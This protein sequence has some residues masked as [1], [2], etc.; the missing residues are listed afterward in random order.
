ML[1]ISEQ[2]AS[3]ATEALTLVHIADAVQKAVDQGAWA[4]LAVIAIY[5]FIEANKATLGQKMPS[6]KRNA[7]QIS[8]GVGALGGAVLA[9][10]P[11]NGALGG[12]IIGN[13]ASGFYASF[14]KPL[15][16]VFGAKVGATVWLALKMFFLA[17]EGMKNTSQEE[18]KETLKELDEA[19]KKAKDKERPSTKELEK[20]FSKHV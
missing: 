2:V 5:V 7:A 8:A 4:F 10:D 12:L 3:Q 9:E 1:D 13:A 6:V 15:M 14:M 19:L 20:W 18:K 11:V 16:A 17:R